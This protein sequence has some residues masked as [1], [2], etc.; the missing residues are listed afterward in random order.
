MRVSRYCPAV[1]PVSLVQPDNLQG[2]T[3]LRR[4]NDERD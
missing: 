1:E 4:P 2:I 3:T